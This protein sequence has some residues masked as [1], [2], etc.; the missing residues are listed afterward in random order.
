MSSL[1]LSQVFTDVKVIPVVD[2]ETI[3]NGYAWDFYNHGVAAAIKNDNGLKLGE[4]FTLLLDFLLM[5]KVIKTSLSELESVNKNDQ[6]LRTFNILEET[7]NDKF[8]KA[9][10]RSYGLRPS[11]RF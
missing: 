5:L 10:N 7:F 1:F 3:Y 4:D 2:L 6:V 9:Y 11:D 8:Q